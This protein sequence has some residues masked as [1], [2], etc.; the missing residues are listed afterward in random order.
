MAQEERKRS[1]KSTE[2]EEGVRDDSSESNNDGE[3]EDE[4][5]THT[6]ETSPP[7]PST[8]TRLVKPIRY[9]DYK[10][11]TSIDRHPDLTGDI[12]VKSGMGK[13]VHPR[14]L[15]T[16]SEMTKNFL[17]G[18]VPLEVTRDDK[19]KKFE[20]DLVGVVAIKNDC[21]VVENDFEPSRALVEFGVV[22]G[23]A[24]IINHDGV[25]IGEFSPKFSVTSGGGGYSPNVGGDFSGIDDGG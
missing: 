15:S 11:E 10:F 1:E 16:L 4:Q 21:R 9:S 14:I 18:F 8:D 2:E 17:T 3:G 13:I 25:E 19:I 6:T 24:T 5:R 7:S 23:D 12:I 20:R 22:G